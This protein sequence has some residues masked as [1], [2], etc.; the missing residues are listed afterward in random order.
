MSKI[1][2]V[3]SE[4]TP[5]AK[6]GGLAD[7]IG[8]LPAA[9]RNA[10]NEVRV[11][12]P[13]YPSALAYVPQMRRVYNNLRFQMAGRSYQ[14]DIRQLDWN[15]IPFYF[16]DCPA[17]YAREGLYGDLGSDYPDNHIRFAVL[18][19][20]A[21]TVARWLFRPEVIHC[22][23][24]QTA[25]I[26]PILKTELQNDPTFFG[27]KLLMTVHNLGYQGHF[28]SSSLAD[29]GMDP[30]L[31]QPAAMEF[32]GG[33]NF[34]KGGL[35]F[36][37][38]INTVSEGYA[39][40]IQTPEYGFGLDGLLRARANVLS[41]ILNGVDYAEWSPET[42]RF[43][44]KNYSVAD[45]SGKRVCKKD[46]LEEFG[47]PV[48]DLDRLLFRIV[49]RCVSQK[50]FDLLEQIAYE[51]VQEDVMLVVI[52][53]GEQ[54]YED[55]F[56]GLA[57]NNPTRVSV[58]VAYDDSIAHKVEAGADMFLMPSRYE[59]CGLNQIYSLRFGT[60]PLV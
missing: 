51:L 19:R 60:V 32:Y 29:V 44:V 24:W 21:L 58:K 3:A 43:I 26:A 54:R 47:L 41:G 18:C 15:G 42:D 33:V 9:L 4:A 36:I 57:W 22:H 1:L 56:R 53:S 48:D 10:G 52:G 30:A 59:P 39:R 38:W 28:P 12:L 34:L 40:E 37:D 27:V 8:A 6:T 2:M 55:V 5:F 31:Y 35:V 50:G 13:L 11:V 45:L 23:D 7:V 25:L 46:L 16:L 17:L 49:S 20:A 14:V